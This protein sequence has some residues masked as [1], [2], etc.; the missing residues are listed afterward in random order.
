[1]GDKFRKVQAGE[2]VVFSADQWN[3]FVDAAQA[4]AQAELDQLAA[5]P[6]TFRDPDVVRVKNETGRDLPRFAVVGLGQPMFVPGV[7][8]A[9]FAREVTFRGV[10]PNG[11]A[12]RF[13]LLLEPALQG[14]V[15]KAQVSGVCHARLNVGDASHGCAEANDG[16]TTRLITRPDGSAQVLWKDAGTGDRWGVVRFSSLC[17]GTPDSGGGGGGRADRCDCPEDTYEVKLGCGDCDDAYGDDATMP[18][19]WWLRFLD[20]DPYGGYGG[21][22]YGNPCAVPCS[23]L[24]GSRVRI[25]NETYGPYQAPTCVW[26]GRGACVWVELKIVGNFWQL[27]ITDKNGCVLATLRKPVAEFNCCGPNVGWV[28]DA[29]SVCAF[30]VELVPHECT[31]CPNRACPPDDLPLCDATPCCITQCTI[32]ATVQNLFS[33]SGV[34]CTQFGSPCYDAAGNPCP[35]PVGDIRRLGCWSVPPGGLPPQRCGAMNGSYELRWVR[36]CEWRFVGT[37]AGGS[38]RVV[39]QLL[40]SGNTWT[41][42]LVGAD[43]QV[44]VFRKTGC[45]TGPFTLDFVPGSSTCQTTSPAPN[46]QLLIS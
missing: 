1:M 24:I 34:S 16:D 14:R 19:Y 12:G 41:L 38:T 46:A 15:A 31:C 28:A 17:L 29:S 26:S 9:Q 6:S 33:P 39:A 10:V 23:D 3:A 30:V 5:Q 11:H 44:A 36:D 35:W 40:I 21:Y 27:T 13:A 20:V 42:R 25:K 45:P 22:G 4:N 18:K 2:P 8:L 37:P 7:N 32:L 43:G